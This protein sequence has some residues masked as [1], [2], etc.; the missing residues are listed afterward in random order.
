VED[1]KTVSP[2]AGRSE[3][4]IG[5]TIS[6]LILLLFFLLLL[7]FGYYYMQTDKREKDLKQQIVVLQVASSDARAALNAIFR[8]LGKDP[9]PDDVKA[10]VTIDK[11]AELAATAKDQENQAKRQTVA[12][13]EALKKLRERG[14][15]ETKTTPEDFQKFSDMTF[16]RKQAE[17]LSL[18]EKE[19][20]D[21]DRRN[22]EL[23][24]KLAKCTGKGGDYVA[25]WR[26][27]DG[28]IQYMFEATITARGMSIDR[29]WPDEREL[30]MSR[31]PTEKG[32]VG[33]TVSAEEFLAL[34]SASFRDSEMKHCRHYVVISGDKSAMSPQMFTVFHRIQDH[35]Y[36]YINIR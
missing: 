16:C 20:T 4:V 12:L 9:T 34:T 19:A 33:K 29:K 2:N 26:G 6:E 30:E 36:P 27:A 14:A 5:T 18:K 3:F 13:Q 25:C 24:G 21:A 10:L 28:K 32:L 8:M 17:D 7:L 1:E 23:Q 11:A 22:G 31:F 15:I 35:F